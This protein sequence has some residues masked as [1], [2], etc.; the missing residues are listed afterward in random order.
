MY[1]DKSVKR[2]STLQEAITPGKLNNGEATKYGFGWG[3]DEPGK[4]ISHTGGWVGFRTIIIRYIDKNQ[5][6]IL[7]DNSSNFRAH[8]L[9]RNIWEEKPITLPTTHLITNVKV[10]DGTD[11][12]AFAGGCAHSE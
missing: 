5:T 12:P 1:T 4:T 3:I 8:R 10:I 6:I 9:V 2:K 7:L 11:L